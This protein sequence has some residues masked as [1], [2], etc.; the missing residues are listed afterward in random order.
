MVFFAQSL[1]KDLEK[2]LCI[3]L[4]PT[5]LAVKSM[6][7]HGNEALRRDSL[8]IDGPLVQLVQHAL[9]TLRHRAA[10]KS[11]KLGQIHMLSLIVLLRPRGVD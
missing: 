5:D 7:K 4:R 3:L 2:L 1:R 10:L 8:P 6:L 11:D 9:Q